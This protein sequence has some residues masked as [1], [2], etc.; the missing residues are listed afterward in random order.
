M[1]DQVLFDY[2]EDTQ[3]FVDLALHFIKTQLQQFERML[4]KKLETIEHIIKAKMD[5]IETKNNKSLS[6]FT[7]DT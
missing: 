5:Q 6:L 2:M 7:N 4:M 3:R 1:N